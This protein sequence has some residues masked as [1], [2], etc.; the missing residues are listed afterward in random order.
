MRRATIGG[1]E[2]N[3]GN[4]LGIELQNRAVGP[5]L[6]MSDSIVFEFEKFTRIM[7]DPEVKITTLLMLVT[8]GKM[9]PS[10][11]AEV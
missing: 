5:P 8:R 3:P 11:P 10:A 1:F 4:L 9:I 6:V 7:F 2:G